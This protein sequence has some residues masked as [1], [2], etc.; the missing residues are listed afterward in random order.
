MIT[1]TIK[2]LN[3]S[4]F[5]NFEKSL[6]MLHKHYGTKVTAPCVVWLLDDGHELTV[7]DTGPSN[8]EIALR[9]H[10]Y[11]MEQNQTLTEQLHELGI[12]T[13][14]IQN[15]ILTHLHWDHASNM[16]VFPNATFYVQRRELEYAV[17][18]LRV[19]RAAYD[20]GRDITPPWV[21]Y[22]GRLQV[23]DGDFLFPNGLSLHLL[24]GHTPGSQGVRVPTDE[25]SF[26]IAGDNVDLYENWPTDFG[27]LPVPG[28]I[29]VNLEEYLL[30]LEKM[31]GL[32]DYILPAHDREVFNSLKKAPT[33]G[34][35]N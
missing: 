21:Q 12:N 18:P 10:G 7:V 3:I 33:G 15:V 32:A 28:G 13:N 27:S 1:F 5:L 6:F 31:R 29:F 8:P 9:Y 24:P 26:L 20:I 17:N 14:D 30:S 2:P 4:N 35:G 34:I 22:I 23:V 16:D 19:N 11:Q 25:G